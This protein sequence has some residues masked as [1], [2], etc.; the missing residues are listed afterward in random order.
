MARSFSKSR[1]LSLLQ[2]EKRFWLEL[3]RP[4]LR[5]DSASTRAS[6]ATGH[7]VGAIARKLYD[8]NGQGVEIDLATDG[9]S[10]ALA[11]TSEL[12]AE[13]RP[14]FEAG[15]SAHGGLAFADIVLPGSNASSWRMV[16]VKSSTS[17]KDYQ[18]DDAAIQAYVARR[19]GIDL[20]SIAIAHIDSGWVYQGDGN[21]NGLLV[22]SDITEEAFSRSEE[23]E[24]WISRAQSIAAQDNEPI[25]ST[26]RHC[27]SPYECGLHAYCTKQEPPVD[28]PLAWLPGAQSKALKQLVEERGVRD[29]RDVPDTALNKRQLLVKT[30][31]LAKSAFFDAA[32]ARAKLAPYVLP[33]YFLDLETISFGIPIWKGTRPYQ[34]MPFQFSLHSIDE[35]GNLDHDSFLDLSGHDPSRPFADALIAACGKQGTIFAYN[36]SFEIGRLKDVAERH[37]DLIEPLLSIASRVVDLLP[38]AQNHYYH[39]SQHGS[40]SIKA[41]IPAVAPDLDYHNLAGVQDGG[42]AMDAYLAAVEPDVSDEHRENIRTQL[43]DYCKLDTYAMVRLWQVFA[44]RDDLNLR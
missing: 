2:C 43:L 24:E 4:E 21:Y 33:L 25:K 3:Y 28:F 13:P 31:T 36:A 1:L 10:R 22:E 14:I 8:L 20:Q 5:E 38:I 12:M 11:R 41:V 26:G 15:F 18:R 29:L 16:E 32:G 27:T 23:V 40:W 30:Q 6:F 17:V 34:Q 37:P 39:P 44:G 7:S 42:M 35:N 19:A 9:V